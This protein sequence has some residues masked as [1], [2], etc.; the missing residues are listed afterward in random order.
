MR[1]HRRF[2]LPFALL[3]A[4]PIFALFGMAISGC[5]GDGQLTTGDADG[6]PDGLVGKIGEGQ[7]AVVSVGSGAFPDRLLPNPAD[8]GGATGA[9]DSAVNPG[10]DGAVAPARDAGQTPAA[11]AAPPPPPT[12]PDAASPP[13]PP[14]PPP[15]DTPTCGCAYGNGRYCASSARDLEGPNGC[16]AALAHEHPDDLLRCT[17]GSWSVEQSCGNGCEVRP[18]GE[19]DRCAAG[20]PVGDDGQWHLPWDCGTT[21][22]CTQGNF[23]DICGGGTGS[24]TGRQQYAYDFGMP[25]GTTVRAARAGEVIFSDNL[26]GP[27]DACFGGCDT[28]DCCNACLNTVN[29]VVLRHG[30]G[31]TSLYLHLTRATAQVG[32]MVN[33]G[34]ELGRSGQSGCSFGA[35]LHF[36]VQTDCGIWFCDSVEAHFAEDGGMACGHNDA[37]GNCH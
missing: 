24:H 13:P 14:P 29:R 4:P 9:A 21:F 35:H 7:D 2:G 31:T 6:G 8:D 3:A 16:Q 1:S 12:D 23:G 20:G 36:Q 15:P 17:D 18:P 19:A 28:Q 30:D 11:D 5:E 37:S 22:P 10:Y 27:G 26:V 34:D 25:A 33:A 32:S